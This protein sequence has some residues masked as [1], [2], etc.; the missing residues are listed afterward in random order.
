MAEMQ[1]AENQEQSQVSPPSGDK[2]P[3]FYFTYLILIYNLRN[4]LQII[5]KYHNNMKKIT[6]ENGTVV[7]ISDESYE[8][9]SK[10]VR[11]P[12]YDDILK[13]FKKLNNYYCP[14]VAVLSDSHYKKIY[15]IN[16]MIIVA[17]YLNGDWKPDWDNGGTKYCLQIEDNRVE[18]GFNFR[19]VTACVYFKTREIAAR[20]IEILG[21][22]TIKTALL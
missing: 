10:A 3:A 15:A 16:S 11:V 19:L 13:E 20:A 22:E 7:E 6:L 14:S 8:A 1:Q 4:Y 9:L 21:E 17:Q 2:I 12:T 5:N 18:L